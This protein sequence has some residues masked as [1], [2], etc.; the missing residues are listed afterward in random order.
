MGPPL[1][2]EVVLPHHPFEAGSEAAKALRCRRR[3]ITPNRKPKVA[4]DDAM[5][6]R[7]A[8]LPKVCSR[9]IC[10]HL[11]EEFCMLRTFPL[12]QSWQVAVDQDE[13]IDSLPRLVLPAGTDS[14]T[15][16]F[17]CASVIHHFSPVR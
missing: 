4:I 13:E 12:S 6:A 3:A 17:L 7:F 16:L 5:E 15:M 14:E 10:H 9:L 11:V 1:D 2:G 8:L